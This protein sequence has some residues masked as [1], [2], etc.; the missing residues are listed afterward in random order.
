M[1]SFQL[2]NLDLFIDN[3]FSF[4]N[5]L[6]LTVEIRNHQ[7]TPLTLFHYLFAK[8]KVSSTLIFQAMSLEFKVDIDAHSM[9][10]STRVITFFLNVKCDKIRVE[11]IMTQITIR[12]L[13]MST[14]YP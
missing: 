11:T 12:N 4:K 7:Q 9:V 13:F 10:S 1:N 3:I 5:Q 8:Y 6:T 14:F 2:N